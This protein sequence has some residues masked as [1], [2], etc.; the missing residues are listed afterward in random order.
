MSDAGRGG[1]HDAWVGGARARRAGGRRRRRWTVTPLR[2]PV[3]VW[4]A[5]EP[6]ASSGPAAVPGP[7]RRGRTGW[8]AR[9]RPG[10]C[11][12][13]RARGRGCGPTSAASSPASRVLYQGLYRLVRLAT[14][15]P[16]SAYAS[17]VGIADRKLA[18]SALCWTTGV[19]RADETCLHDLVTEQA[20]RTPDAVAVL[21]DDGVL[22][23]ADPVAS[24]NRLA[25]RLRARGVDVD[26]PVGVVAQRGVDLV[27]TV[28]GVLVA[29]G[30][31]VPLDPDLAAERLGYQLDDA[32]PPV[33]LLAQ[34]H[35]L[36]RVNPACVKN[37]GRGGRR[38]TTGAAT[39]TASWRVPRRSR[40]HPAGAG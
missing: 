5:A 31:Y 15:A 34:R 16:V 9:H 28:L 11:C 37:S 10:P 23:Y 4:G 21:A 38:E 18:D 29:G 27:V 13:C 6:Y 2:A 22:R 1:I 24:A 7:Y 26:I 39:P 3:A 35:L 32:D 19:P 30:A 33:V 14:N 12:P 25:H 17:A 36:A 40:H 8:G 20:A